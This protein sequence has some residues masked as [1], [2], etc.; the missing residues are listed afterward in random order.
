M[1]DKPSFVLHKD[2]LVILDKMTNEQAGQFIK[3]IRHYQTT[4]EVLSVDFGIDMA[5]APFIN[6]FVRDDA[7]WNKEA[8]KK[9]ESGSLGNL[10]RWNKDIY[11][12]VVSDK[13]TL[14]EGIKLSQDVAKDRTAIKEVAKIAVNVNV[15][16]SVNGNVSVSENVTVKKKKK[17]VPTGGSE[18]SSLFNH[19]KSEFIMQYL[20]LTGNEFY[21]NAK[22][23]GSLKTLINQIKYSVKE[24]KEKN[25]AEK[26]KSATDSEVLESLQY[27]L[28][29]LPD[30]FKQ[31]LSLAI[32]SS[33]YNE[34][35]NQLRNGKGSKINELNNIQG[36]LNKIDK[37][38]S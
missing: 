12:Q 34:L 5:V 18:T 10:K 23:A 24:K 26:E 31:N 14:A 36:A 21:F 30:W 3:T 4:G 37:L 15:S 20:A 2:S 13:I 32:L 9:S 1:S 33:K 16:D 27:I 17:K 11:D 38:Y 22:S 29:N 19:C 6:Q 28:M 7:R 25:S 8:K 35:I